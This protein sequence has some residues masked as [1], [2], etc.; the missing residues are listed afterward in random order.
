VT[1]PIKV[2]LAQ[3]DVKPTHE[4]ELNEKLKCDGVKFKENFIMCKLDGFE[5]IK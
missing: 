4:V 2:Q 1:N 5:T 3:G